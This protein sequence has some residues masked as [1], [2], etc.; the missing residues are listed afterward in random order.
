MIFEYKQVQA[1]KGNYHL[2]VVMSSNK[3]RLTQTNIWEG[4]PITVNKF[5]CPDWRLKIHIILKIGEFY[6][7]Q[8][9]GFRAIHFSIMESFF[10]GPKC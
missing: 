7:S 8:F 1:R 9:Y 2:T 6:G 4:K 5:T 10:G 3:E